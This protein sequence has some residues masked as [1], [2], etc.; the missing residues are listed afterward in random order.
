MSDLARKQ[1]AK[2]K[3][4]GVILA[5]W[6]GSTSIAGFA[7][8]R[9]WSLVQQHRQFIATHAMAMNHRLRDEDI[10][11]PHIG[12]R[13]ISLYLPPRERLMSKYLL[14]AVGRNERIRPT[15]VAGHPIVPAIPCD[16]CQRPMLLA[17][18]EGEAT[19]I[20][21]GSLVDYKGA[22][23]TPALSKRVA[24]VTQI[25]KQS[26]AAVMMTDTEKT[27]A[28]E[29]AKLELRSAWSDP[30][31]EVTWTE[32]KKIDV[33]SRPAGIWTLALPWVP[34]GTRLR[35]ESSGKWKYDDT[36]MCGPDGDATRPNTGALVEQAALGAVVGK[37]GGSSAG[38]K[39]GTTFVVGSFTVYDTGQNSGPLF[40][41]INVPATKF[42]S[43]N[44][45]ISVTITEPK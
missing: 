2:N 23:G 22:K 35:I 31:Q 36:T 30:M 8:W 34:A 37:L 39:D 27:N 7:V 11:E 41:T 19:A 13:G 4:L 42:P 15:D 38:L 3:V 20:D 40:L 24:A 9:R 29:G 25:G 16:G 26:Y 1:Q 32:V 18:G 33:P 28:G 45:V 44:E 6:L 21:A 12:V 14:H 43:G 17:I 10:T 5:L